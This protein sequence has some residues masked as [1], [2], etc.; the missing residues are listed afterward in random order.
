MRRKA[1]RVA[2]GVLILVGGLVGS[3]GAIRADDAC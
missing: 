1:M 2:M 3:S